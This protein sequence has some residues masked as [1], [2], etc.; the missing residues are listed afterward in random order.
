[1]SP[2]EI[3]EELVCHL[4]RRPLMSRCPNCAG[5]PP[6]TEADF[7]KVGWAGHHQTGPKPPDEYPDWLQ[8]VWF[9]GNPVGVGE[10]YPE[11]EARPSDIAPSNLTFLRGRSGHGL[12]KLHA[13]LRS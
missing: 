7:A 11:N 13:G 1:M 8:Q 10:S 2:S 9:A 3:G 6:R 5:F 12:F 4:L